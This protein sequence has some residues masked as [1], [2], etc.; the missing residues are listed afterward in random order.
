MVCSDDT[1]TLGADCWNDDFPPGEC[2]LLQITRQRVSLLACFLLG[3]VGLQDNTSHSESATA[4]LPVS[5]LGTAHQNT[6]H[7]AQF[8]FPSQTSHAFA[9]S[10]FG[11]DPVLSG[12]RVY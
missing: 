5:L 7:Q 4:I 12:K 11:S 10:S 2:L 9:I 8:L 6:A 3:S 1:G